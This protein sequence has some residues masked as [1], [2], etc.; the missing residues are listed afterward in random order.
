MMARYD[1]YCRNCGYF[2]AW[3]GLED[4][5]IPCPQCGTSARRTAC[6]GSPTIRGET[7][8]KSAPGEV[9]RG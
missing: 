7:V 2:E 4:Y 8:G 9:W 3:T 5:V 1:Y 6:S